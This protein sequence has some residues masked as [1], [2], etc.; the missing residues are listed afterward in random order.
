MA[1][2]INTPPHP[3]T[4]WHALHDEYTA[5]GGL[6]TEFCRHKG[7]SHTLAIKIFSAIDDEKL[8]HDKKLIVRELVNA[9][10]PAAKNLRSLIDSEDEAISLK[11]SSEILKSLALAPKE[12]APVI[13]DNSV[14]VNFFLP[15]NGRGKIIEQTKLQD[16]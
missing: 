14:Q 10:I 8:V 3:D 15:E 16:G 5:F 7:I 2:L 4:N 12:S 6:L 1:D 13:T 9:G 11:A